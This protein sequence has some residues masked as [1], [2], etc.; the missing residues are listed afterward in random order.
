MDIF[1]LKYTNIP[2][3]YTQFFA[4]FTPWVGGYY[5]ESD[6]GPVWQGAPS[7][8][9]KTEVSYDLNW[10]L[11]WLSGRDV[12]IRV[13]LSPD[14]RPGPIDPYVGPFFTW[15][16]PF[17]GPPFIPE[18]GGIYTFNLTT[19]DWF[20]TWGSGEGLKYSRIARIE[21]PQSAARGSLVTIRATIESIHLQPT[22]IAAFTPYPAQIEGGWRLL[23]PGVQYTWT[24][25]FTMPDKS[26]TVPIQAMHLN[27]TGGIVV[28]EMQNVNIALST[29]PPPPP[30]PPPPSGSN[31]PVLVGLGAVGLG[32]LYLARKGMK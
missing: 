8:P 1:T 28:D 11:G 14:W 18:K 4:G 6:Q 2:P 32:A 19:L 21:A 15:E 13:Y 3:R 25:S 12:R 5:V 23:Y 17:E 9:T 7:D 20:V 30:P 24:I 31:V 10:I 22:Y 26:V 27:D 16:G 29:V